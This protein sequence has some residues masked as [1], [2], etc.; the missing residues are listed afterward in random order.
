MLMI[1]STYPGLRTIV[2]NKNRILIPNLPNQFIS[3]PNAIFKDQS[4]EVTPLDN[5]LGDNAV[6]QRSS[7]EL[8]V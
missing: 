5:A 7:L 6:C 8:T 4:L 1:E 2:P 3:L